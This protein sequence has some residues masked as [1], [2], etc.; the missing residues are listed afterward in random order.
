[1]R[2]HEPSIAS[3]GQSAIGTRHTSRCGE[4]Q[5]PGKGPTCHLLAVARAVLDPSPK[6]RS[7]SAYL[8]ITD[9]GLVD[10]DHFRL[11][12]LAAPDRRDPSPE[13]VAVGLISGEG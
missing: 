2:N 1:M 8:K 6:A 11:V 4:L 5:R 7:F 12:P 9:R 10:V 13:A 3:A